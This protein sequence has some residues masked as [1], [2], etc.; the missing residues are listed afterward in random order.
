VER[1]AFLARVTAA[2]AQA[3]L[4]ETPQ[5]LAELPEMGEADLVELFRVRAQSVNTVV[6]GPVTRHGAPRAVVGIASGHNLES[7]VIWDRLPASG[8]AS[9]LA[10]AGFERIDAEVARGDR[11]QPL[12]IGRA[13]LGVTGS[14]FA[15]AESG[16]VVLSH[17]PGRGR[18]VSLVPEIHI[19]LVT[20]STM[21]RT[22]AHWAREF[23]GNAAETANL[24]IVTGPSRTGDIELELTLGVHGPRHMHV[25]LIK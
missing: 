2:A 6:H 11:R 15:L 25:I 23:P 16:S 9:A 18:L 20:T 8:V 24:V 19:A 17:G 14:D 13:D 1:D 7:F 5:V 22:L 21:H 10:T 3:E 12:D 4:P